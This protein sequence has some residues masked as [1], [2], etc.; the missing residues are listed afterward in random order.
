MICDIEDWMVVNWGRVYSVCRPAMPTKTP[1]DTASANYFYVRTLY[2]NY[3]ALQH[4][5]SPLWPLM[6]LRIGKCLGFTST[7][8]QGVHAHA[9]KPRIESMDLSVMYRRIHKI[10]A[11]QGDVKDCNR[12][13]DKCP[14]A[15]DI[16]ENRL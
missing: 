9:Y 16:D 4:I 7:F 11:A 3:C 1:G 6:K 10:C 8:M 13:H 2:M 14:E 12:P 5:K 15:K